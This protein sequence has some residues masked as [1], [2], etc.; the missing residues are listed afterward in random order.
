MSNTGEFVHENPDTVGQQG[1]SNVSH[2]CINL[3][4]ANA[5]WFFNHFG[6]GDVV[7]VANSGG[8]PLGISDLYGDWEVP[9]ATWSKGNA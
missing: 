7:E 1:H 9:W 3:S 5:E 8:P 4:E 6:V 2:G